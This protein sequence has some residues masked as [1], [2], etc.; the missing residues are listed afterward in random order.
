M[1]DIAK[2]RELLAAATP[3]PW[4]DTWDQVADGRV[5]DQF[6][7][8]TDAASD[9][10]GGCV[11]GLIEY[12]GENVAVRKGDAALIVAAVNALPSLLDELERLQRDGGAQ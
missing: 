8:V 5:E 4:R 9:P 11:V 6:A 1:V 7:I 12:D 2:L 10:L 3:R